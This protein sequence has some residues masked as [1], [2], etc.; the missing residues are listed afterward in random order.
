ME[1]GESE[2]NNFGKYYFDKTTNSII[3]KYIGVFTKIESGFKFKETSENVKHFVIEQKKKIG[4]QNIVI[5]Y[6]CPLQNEK[7]YFP[8]FEKVIK[9]LR[10]KG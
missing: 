3:L 8:L 2:K 1:C 5:R 4:K 6:V 10:Q 9:S 7:T